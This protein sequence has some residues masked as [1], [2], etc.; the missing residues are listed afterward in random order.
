VTTR[1]SEMT[2]SGELYC[3]LFN[4]CCSKLQREVLCFEERVR[5]QDVIKGPVKQA[6]LRL[7]RLCFKNK[8]SDGIGRVCVDCKRRVCNECGSFSRRP[9][10]ANEKT[11]VG[12]LLQLHYLSLKTT[13]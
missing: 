13:F 12:L 10:G 7:C 3:L 8:F 4:C 6:D 2:C 11:K 9:I 1:S 5:Q